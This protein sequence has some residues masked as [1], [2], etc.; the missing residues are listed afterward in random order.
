[1]VLLGG[2]DRRE[3]LGDPALERGAEVN[4]KPSIFPVQNLH[5]CAARQRHDQR[6]RRAGRVTYVE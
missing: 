6:S 4:E 3:P 1:M 2:P 5:P